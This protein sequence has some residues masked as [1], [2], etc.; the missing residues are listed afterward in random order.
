ME[1]LYVFFRGGGVQ[2]RGSEQRGGG[3]GG[4]RVG[5]LSSKSGVV[6]LC[7]VWVVVPRVCGEDDSCNQSSGDVQCYVM[8]VKYQI[9]IYW[10]L[11]GIET[12]VWAAGQKVD[13][14]LSLL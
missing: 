4:G 13:R 5:A 9:T 11:L 3:A 12:I 14:L 2:Y 1:F 8:F 6:L 10:Y 7:A